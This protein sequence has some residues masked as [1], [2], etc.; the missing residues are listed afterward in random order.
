MIEY[1]TLRREYCER[2]KWHPVSGLWG[3]PFELSYSDFVECQN[4][5]GAD[6]SSWEIFDKEVP[7]EE[8]MITDI[9]F[10][11]GRVDYLGAKSIR[12]E[13][14][15]IRIAKRNTKNGNY[16]LVHQY[17]IPPGNPFDKRITREKARRAF[18][19]IDKGTSVSGALIVCKVRY[20]A[21]LR[22]TDYI[23]IR[24]DLRRK[25]I[26]QAI[27]FIKNG[28]KLADVLFHLKLSSKTFSRWTGGKKFITNKH[29]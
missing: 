27:K 6:W 16:T 19:M 23:P 25:K 20:D 14:P 17:H 28:W 11:T 15:I 18:A 9:E 13:E 29:R 4:K 8:E 26:S 1:Q 12:L 24:S 3:R 2:M 21:L 10:H 7:D 22:Y 5:F